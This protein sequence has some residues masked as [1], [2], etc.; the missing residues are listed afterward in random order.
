M[1][2]PVKKRKYVSPARQAKAEA[3]RGR[4]VEAA[5]KL[6][7]ENGYGRVSTA[8]IAK[9]ARTS[10]ASV[11]AGFGSKAQLLVEIVYDRVGSDP[12]APSRNREKWLALAADKDKTAAF[13][14]FARV[15][16]R[17][18]DRSWRLLAIAAAAAQDDPTVAE[19]V[20][21]G[22]EGRRARAAW[23]V[24]EIIGITGKDA[25]RRTDEVWTL[26]SVENYRR[27]VVERSW[28]PGQ[29]EAWL[30]SM[31]AATLI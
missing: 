15:V 6:F 5:A 11:F 16:R 30:A 26:I 9:A 8:A 10:E 19:V 28:P 27:L 29:F 17:F 23:F 4:I 14:Q 1:T 22:A 20:W 31:L 18:H 12:E 2:E 21:Q 24:R 13:K 7:L 25:K 3:T